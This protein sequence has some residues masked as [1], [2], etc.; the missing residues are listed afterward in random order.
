MYNKGSSGKIGTGV[1]DWEVAEE[2]RHFF[3]AE[4]RMLHMRSDGAQPHPPPPV[5]GAGAGAGEGPGPGEGPVV[6]VGPFPPPVDF[7][8]VFEFAAT[9]DALAA[10]AAVSVG[11]G[12]A[13]GGAV[14]R[15]GGVFAAV[16]DVCA[17]VSGGGGLPDAN[18]NTPIIAPTANTAPMPMYIGV[19]F[20]CG[21]TGSGVETVGAA[22]AVV[23]D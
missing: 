17:V 12:A 15:G 8:G 9:A 22:V 20:F 19:R 10:A 2:Q 13:V 16:G 18:T 5:L 23:I 4:H 3:L 7:G 6:L 21:L 11:G 1:K 14:S